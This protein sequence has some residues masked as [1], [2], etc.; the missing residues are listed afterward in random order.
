MGIAEGYRRTANGKFLLQGRETSVHALHSN[1][2]GQVI[3]QG[4]LDGNVR[5]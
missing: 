2:N 5:T 3:K 1:K 4:A